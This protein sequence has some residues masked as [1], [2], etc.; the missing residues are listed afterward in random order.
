MMNGL[1]V[2]ALLA[3]L[4]SPVLTGA[5]SAKDLESSVNSD[6]A[7]DFLPTALTILSPTDRRVIGHGRYSVTETDGTEVVQGENEYLD[8]RHDRELE[9]LKL[10]APGEARILL[11][12]EHSF[13]N[14]DGS[15]RVVNRLDTQFGAAS[16]TEHVNGA[17]RVRQSTLEVP[18]DTY[19]GAAQLM[20]IVARL[21]QGER[22]RIGFHSFTCLP[23]PKII[24]IEAS[25]AAKRERWPMYPGELARIEIQP[26]LGW[27][28]RILIAPFIP[29]ISGWL[30][31]A[32]NWN[33][34]GATFDRYYKGEH[35]LTVRTVSESPS[36]RQAAGR[37]EVGA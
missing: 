15:P 32:D 5:G 37:Q 33:Y 36:S 9:R 1:C 28:L 7:F 3:A 27:W 34:V 25:V 26:D 24:P 22:E 8:G 23:G 17:V 12:A 18:A 16:C 20:L 4:M 21:R 29:K 30:D 31:P 13:F 2:L 10:G 6:S 11:S 19:A 14:A 35:I